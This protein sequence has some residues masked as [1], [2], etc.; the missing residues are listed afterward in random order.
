MLETAAGKKIMLSG[1]RIELSPQEIGGWIKHNGWTL[2]VDPGASLSWPIYPFNPYA[3]KPEV[4]LVRAVGRLTVPL[5]LKE[6]R[7]QYVRPDEQA[8]AFVLK[9]N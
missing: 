8:I 7:G 6:M 4:N 1:E 9:T 3:N 5:Q 2:E